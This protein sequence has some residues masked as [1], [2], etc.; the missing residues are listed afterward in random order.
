MTKET[1]I[2]A[3]IASNRVSR[4]IH[5][6]ALLARQ[7]RAIDYSHKFVITDSDVARDKVTKGCCPKQDI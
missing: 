3:V 1:D 4:F 6:T 5:K 2:Q 7:R